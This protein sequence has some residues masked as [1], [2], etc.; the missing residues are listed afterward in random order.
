MGS[1]LSAMGAA[2]DF[3]HA[4]L[5]GAW[6]LGLPLLFWRRWPL[7]T[8]VYAAF[9]IAFVVV[10]L[11]SRALL[12]ECVLTTAARF[13]WDKAAASSGLPPA[14]H[15]WFTVRAAE[16]IFKLT[17]SHRSIK[18]TSEV[19]ILVTAV[20]VFLSHRQAKLGHS[21]VARLALAS[22]HRTRTRRTPITPKVPCSSRQLDAAPEGDGR[23]GRELGRFEGSKP[24]A[25]ARSAPGT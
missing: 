17:P 19:L 3:A 18:L 7:A 21:K 23:G 15:E 5:M 24:C 12:G 25:S 14:S 4:T 20:G 2:V 11:T 9:A 13:F 16:A 8:R 22:W 1:M 6:V 10:N